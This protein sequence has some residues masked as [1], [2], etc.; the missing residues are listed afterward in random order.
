MPKGSGSCPGAALPAQS[1][2]HT[3]RSIY[4]VPSAWP[5]PVQLYMYGLHFSYA[6][7]GLWFCNVPPHP[8]YLPQNSTV[9]LFPTPSSRSSVLDCMAP[10][11]RKGINR[12]CES[13]RFT[14]SL[15]RPGNISKYFP[16]TVPSFPR[17]KVLT[18]SGGKKNSLI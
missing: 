6:G 17:G 1:A 12:T 15:L 16:F 7:A 8:R 13:P 9:G 2:E 18:D 3:A 5:S 10:R 14:E 11:F 4:R